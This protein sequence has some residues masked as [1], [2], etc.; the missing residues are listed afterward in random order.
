MTSR[1]DDRLRGDGFVLDEM[2]VGRTGSSEGRLLA[3]AGFILAWRGQR[4]GQR[5]LLGIAAAAATAPAAATAATARR[6][7]GW[8]G[9]LV[10]GEFLVAAFGGKIIRGQ[11]G[12][13]LDLA[14]GVGDGLVG[15]RR[16]ERGLVLEIGAASSASPATPAT[17][18]TTS[19]GR[20]LVA[21]A[22]GGF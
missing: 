19:G 22:F 14:M 2:M 8:G 3:G 4:G 7:L 10:G 5:G 1:A 16:R 11:N 9:E 12:G 21:G 18:A 15:G 17:A 6:P 20:L 13:F